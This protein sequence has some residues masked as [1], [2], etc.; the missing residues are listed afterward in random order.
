MSSLTLLWPGQARRKTPAS[1]GG[2]QDEYHRGT[3]GHSDSGLSTMTV[4]IMEK[5]AGSVAV[6][7]RPALPKTR[8]TSGK[9]LMSLSCVCSNRCA[10][11]T[12]MPGI[13][14]GI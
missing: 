1:Q 12:E 4:S 10:S 9:D 3:F 5:G 14:V 7:A 6:S 11:V 2:A 8:S 13:V